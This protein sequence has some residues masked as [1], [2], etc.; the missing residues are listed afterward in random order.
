M[1]FYGTV[2]VIEIGALEVPWN[3]MDFHD[4]AHV[5]EIG[6]LEVPWNSMDCSCQ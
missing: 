3:S 5:I 2:G 4:T 1:E 6:A